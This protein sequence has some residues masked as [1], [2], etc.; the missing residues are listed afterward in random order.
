MN[1]NLIIGAV[2]I[3]C[4]AAETPSNSTRK[5]YTVNEMLEKRS[6][7]NKSPLAYLDLHLVVDTAEVLKPPVLMPSPQ[8]TSAKHIAPAWN[9]A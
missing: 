5:P 9:G 8:V 7:P 6:E 4:M 3:T 1:L 2:G